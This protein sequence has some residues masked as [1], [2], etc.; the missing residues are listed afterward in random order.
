MLE[1][2]NRARSDPQADLAGCTAGHCLEAACYSTAATPR[3]MN[4][5]LDQSSRFHG[6]HMAI[7]NYFDHYSECT[8]LTNIASLFPNTCGGAASCSC[9]EHVISG[10][11]GSGTDPFTRMGYFGAQVEDA[12]EI[13]AAGYNGP[14]AAFYGWLYEQA[15]TNLCGDNSANGHRFLILSPGSGPQ[16]GAGYVTG[17]SFGTYQ[18]MDFA[19]TSVDTYKI[20]SGSHYPQQ[21]AS[22]D[23]WVNWNDSASPN[24]AQIDVDGVCSNMSLQRGSVMNGAWHQTVT[25]VGSGCHRYLFAFK[26][27][28]GNAMLYP[29]TGSLA[30]GNGT[31]SCPDWTAGAPAICSG[32][33]QGE[34][35]PPFPVRILDTRTGFTTNDGMF[36][37]LGA[38]G[39]G[40]TLNLTVSGRGGV[41]SS[42]V[43]AVAMN[44]TAT[45]TTAA[46]FVTAWP[47]GS[48]RPLA[49]NLNFVPAQTIPNLVI[50][51]IGTNGQV[52][53][54]NSAGKTDLIADVAWYFTTATQLTA[55]NPAR[56]LDTRPGFTTIDGQFAGGGGVSGG[57]QINLTVAGR[58]GLPASGIGAV[59]MNVTATQPTASGFVTV[60][61][62]NAA[63]PVASNLN[64]VA[65]QTIP[66]LVISAVSPAGQV[67]LFNSAGSTDLI[68]D[69]MGWFPTASALTALVPARLLDTRAGKTTTDGKFAGVGALA[70]ANSMQLTVVGRGGVPAS[71]VGAVVL[72]VTATNTSAAGFITAWPTGNLRPVASNLNFVPGQ[73]IPNLVIAAVGSNG[74]VS[75][76]NSAGSTDLV[77]DVVGWLPPGP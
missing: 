35:L 74:T 32:F 37:S 25:G 11:V 60:W 46:G 7:N 75:L 18:V 29:T 39:A 21:A 3:Y 53:L 68:A 6:S 9:S 15:T 69:V 12:G 48:T 64:F 71:G 70:P 57:G 22:V 4:Y 67:S 20:P 52:S 44:V 13:I 59:V 5:D 38:L 72:N 47:A 65:T 2:M 10:V 49:S 62:T 31:A 1:W 34:V 41:P 54:F 19:G 63:R 77:V 23:A 73:T 36:E 24:V 51:K 40:A 50:S 17:G 42:G 56:L 8:I 28:L 33:T 43:A 16:A 55:L 58:G 26:D 27:S 76:F 14:N 45:D 30:I 66:N 61:P